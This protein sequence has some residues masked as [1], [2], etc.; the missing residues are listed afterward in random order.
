MN[1]II[2]I[3]RLLQIFIDLVSQK[4]H[5]KLVLT[6]V[7]V[8]YGIRKSTSRK[9][10]LYVGK[11]DRKNFKTRQST[12]IQKSLSG[13][14]VNKELMLAIKGSKRNPRNKTAKYDIVFDIIEECSEKDVFKREAYYINKYAS[15][16]L[17]NIV[18]PE[19]YD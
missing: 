9:S 3:V 2:I 7:N 17:T 18:R 4:R 16:S 8:I 13:K 15:K 14:H 12:H 1:I 6:E 10:Y 11:S 5:L 19:Y